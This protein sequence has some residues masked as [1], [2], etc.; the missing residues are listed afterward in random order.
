MAR[1]IMYKDTPKLFRGNCKRCE[2]YIEANE[3]E[4]T[5]DKLD[6]CLLCSCPSCGMGGV[7]VYGYEPPPTYNTYRG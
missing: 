6:I 2:A 3:Y 5:P 4:V 7:K 1:V